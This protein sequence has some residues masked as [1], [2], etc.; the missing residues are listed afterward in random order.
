MSSLNNIAT[1]F[2]VSPQ[3][4]NESTEDFIARLIAT[5]P[6]AREKIEGVGASLLAS[7]QKYNDLSAQ[8]DATIEKQF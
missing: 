7:M 8:I 3:A 4:A 5:A 1:E 6:E 2:G